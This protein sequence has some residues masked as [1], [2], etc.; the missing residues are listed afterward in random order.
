MKRWKW[1]LF[2]VS[3]VAMILLL[4]FE[5]RLNHE[6][7]LLEKGYQGEVAFLESAQSME[8]EKRIFKVDMV[9]SFIGFINAVAI[10]LYLTMNYQKL[11]DKWR[12]FK[13]AESKPFLTAL[14]K[15]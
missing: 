10:I 9:L 5:V 15:V 11:V 6:W 8:M 2:G 13:G 3:M 12:K 1:I 4:V 14:Q 7:Y